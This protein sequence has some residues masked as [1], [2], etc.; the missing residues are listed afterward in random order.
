MPSDFDRSEIS[1]INNIVLARLDGL[2]I[3]LRHI[4]EKL[5]EMSD[6]NKDMEARLR[7]LEVQSAQMPF[8]LALLAAGSGLAAGGGAGAL[9]K[10][11]F[12]MG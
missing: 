8:K 3:E 10:A 9:I 6:K 2:H 4:C 12:G 7:T 11:L 1:E 5:D